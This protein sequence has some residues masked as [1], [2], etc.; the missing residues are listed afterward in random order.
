MTTISYS[1]AEQWAYSFL[2]CDVCQFVW[3]AVF[4]IHCKNVECP[5]CEEMRNYERVEDED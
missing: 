5:H 3:L 1:P 2:M 4:E